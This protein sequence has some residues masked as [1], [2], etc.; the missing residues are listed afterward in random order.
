[1]LSKQD[2]NQDLPAVNGNIHYNDN[3]NDNNKNN[4]DNNKN[5]NNEEEEEVD[6]RYF[7]EPEDTE[8]TVHVEEE[9]METYTDDWDD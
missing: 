1:M 9:S 8:E 5:N 2:H 4:S 6:E 7:F 3:K